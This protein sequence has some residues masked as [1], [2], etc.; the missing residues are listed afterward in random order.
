MRTADWPELLSRF[1][2]MAN[3]R[4]SGLSTLPVAAHVAGLRN[5]R[6]AVAGAGLSATVDE[7]VDRWLPGFSGSSGPRYFGFVTGGATP[8]ALFGDWLTSLLDQN[9]M[10]T[11]DSIAPQ[12]EAEALS[13]FRDLID[14]PGEYTG[15]FVTGATMANFVGLSIARQ[16]LGEQ[17]G[18]DVAQ[19]GVQALPARVAILS[20]APHS[21]LF[22]AM[23]MAGLGRNNLQQIATLP[24]REAIDIDALEEALRLMAEPCVVV[25]NAGTVNS[26]DFDD[27]RAIIELKHRYRFWLHVDAAF[28]GYAAC[29]ARY[30]FLVDGLNEADSIAIDAHK[31][32]NVPYDSAL[33]FTRR[34]DLQNRVF[35]NS[36]SYLP[37]AYSP[38]NFVHMTPEN[39]RRLRALP[40]WF[41][42]QAYGREQYAD[43][44]ERH[45]ALARELSDWLMA[46]PGFELLAQPKLNGLCFALRLPGGFASEDVHH[47]YLQHLVEDG[48]V[49]M[50]PTRYL[51]RPAIRVSISNWRTERVDI[52]IAWRAM[53][54]L[55]PNAIPR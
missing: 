16:W 3:E 29:S 14:L 20:G 4:F 8:A 2:Q 37:A 44:I 1:S 21:S 10:G 35:N 12:L 38:T 23:A 34:Q 17:Y 42:L 51:G 31:W 30:R 33:Q 24:Q 50:T 27:L 43:M 45:C 25:A 53:R 7:F 13:L 15:S 5:D 48:R 47:A 39:S 40:V 6:H 36:A 52:E 22:K 11:A 26:T 19:E 9:A 18:V 49:F 54:E 55:H 46:D 28:G 32:L 41:T